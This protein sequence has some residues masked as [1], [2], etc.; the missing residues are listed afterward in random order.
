MQSY[1]WNQKS[2]KNKERREKKEKKVE[3]DRA[4]SPAQSSPTTVA[5]LMSIPKR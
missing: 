5:H 3:V 4:A 1:K 2:E